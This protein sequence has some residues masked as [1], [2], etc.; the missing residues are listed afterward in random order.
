MLKVV[1][2]GPESSGKTVLAEQLA[3][4]F[5]TT[6]VPEYLRVFFDEKQAVFEE[7]MQEIAQKQ[8]KSEENGLKMAQ[9]A[10]F[11]DTNCMTLKVYHQL[12]FDSEP[13][14]FNTLFKKENYDH[15]LL[16]K[17]D[18]PWVDDGQRDMPHRREELFKLFE[19]ELQAI[20]ADYTIVHGDFQSRTSMAIQKVSEL[21]AKV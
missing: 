3:Q 1:L 10:I 21:L 4:H 7:N 8:L 14:W 13:F 18:I 2:I 12:Y 20:E 15:Y 17:P 11:Y 5:E 9:R 19:Q 16:L 6:W